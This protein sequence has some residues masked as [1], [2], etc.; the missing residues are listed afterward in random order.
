MLYRLTKS[1]FPLLSLSCKSQHIEVF[2]PLSQPMLELPHKIPRHPALPYP[3]QDPH[4][5]A[6]DPVSGPDT[7]FAALEETQRVL[8][9]NFPAVVVLVVF[10]LH[11]W[12]C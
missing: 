6:T 11:T 4:L 10:E 7:T 2:D 5:Q 3:L 1:L 9:A 12:I 8:E